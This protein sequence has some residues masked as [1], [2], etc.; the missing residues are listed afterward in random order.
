LG[1][2]RL[3]RTVLVLVRLRPIKRMN[4][5]ADKKKRNLTPTKRSMR[6]W[7]GKEIDQLLEYR[8]T[9]FKHSEIGELMGRSTKSVNVKMSKIMSRIRANVDAKDNPV[10]DLT[11]FQK[12]L[13]S[14]LFGDVS[15]DDKHKK[16]RKPRATKL[17]LTPQP[18]VTDAF[19]VPKKPV[20]AA[21]VLALVV[22]AWYLGSM[23]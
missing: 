3:A 11:P 21:V 22:V 14:T 4:V 10:E 8:A 19:N 18:L 2:G 5:M 1:F 15:P 6:P 13:D 12:N 17:S 23:S 9:G 7:T 20:Y 16:P